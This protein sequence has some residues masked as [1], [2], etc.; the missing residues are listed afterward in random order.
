[1]QLMQTYTERSMTGS[2][3]DL[4]KQAERA[5]RLADQATDHGVIHTLRDAAKDYRMEANRTN[6]RQA[7][8]APRG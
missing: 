2:R 3:N 1:M 6:D 4:L 7:D 5:E 8:F